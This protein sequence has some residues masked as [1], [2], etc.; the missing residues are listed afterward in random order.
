MK[1]PTISI[2]IHEAPPSQAAVNAT[3]T[4][5][6]KLSLQVS[7][8]CTALIGIA[9][10]G[11]LAIQLHLSD[12]LLTQVAFAGGLI[13]FLV[14]REYERVV[15]RRLAAVSPV[16]DNLLAEAALLSAATPAAREYR[17]ALRV[18]KRELTLAEFDAMKKLVA[19]TPLQ[20]SREALYG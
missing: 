18:Q 6:K 14:T 11:F 15:T 10:I 17:D 7:G 1:L 19:N 3:R 16:A 12:T 13:G 2:D 4:E 20:T 5:V 9:C 8:L